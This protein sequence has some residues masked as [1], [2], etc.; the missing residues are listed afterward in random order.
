MS[1][2]RLVLS[3]LSLP[4]GAWWLSHTLYVRRGRAVQEPG[5]WL[6]CRTGGRRGLVPLGDHGDGSSGH[7]VV[8]RDTAFW[9]PVAFGL[10][11]PASV[12]LQRR[13]FL[14]GAPLIPERLP[15][16]SAGDAV[17]I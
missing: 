10:M 12:C 13:R 3:H 15:A 5:R 4:P 16:E 8:S 11:D 1:S 6:L 9:M 2:R 7:V 17:Q 14:Q